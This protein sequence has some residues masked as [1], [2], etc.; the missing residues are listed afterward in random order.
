MIILVRLANGVAVQLYQ[1]FLEKCQRL[2]E[3]A[4]QRAETY[5]KQPEGQLIDRVLRFEDVADCEAQLEK[6]EWLEE[7]PV[8]AFR[9]FIRGV[10]GYHDHRFRLQ[11]LFDG[12]GK[13]VAFHLRHAV[14]GEHEI[15]MI[16]IEA[17]EAFLAAWGRIHN[18]AVL[19][20]HG[21][22]HL[23]DERLVID[24]QNAQLRYGHN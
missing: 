3:T 10:A 21:F 11:T 1:G 18:M 8:D 7:H 5:P 22:H 2:M 23:A 13:L 6:G 9:G 24:N 12:G 16:G 19:H 14:I 20:Q 17:C 4:K 15:K